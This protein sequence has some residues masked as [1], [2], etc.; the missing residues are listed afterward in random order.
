MHV[1]FVCGSFFLRLQTENFMLSSFVFNCDERKAG[2][3]FRNEFDYSRRS[4]QTSFPLLDCRNCENFGLP[5]L[6][7][8]LLK[9]QLIRAFLMNC[10]FSQSPLFDQ[11]SV[12]RLHSWKTSYF[13][14]LANATPD[15]RKTGWGTPPRVS[16]GTL[17]TH[18]FYALLFTPLQTRR[19]RTAL[20]S[21]SVSTRR[22]VRADQFVQQRFRW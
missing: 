9:K 19:R 11:L 16:A 2:R 6:S 18:V 3:C 7:I 8:W 20:T 1:R 4:T 15:K 10:Q 13:E 5:R 22:M 17:T 12:F 21:P 14:I